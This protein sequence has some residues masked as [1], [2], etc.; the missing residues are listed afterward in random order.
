MR[1]SLG[2]LYFSPAK[3]LTLRPQSMHSFSLLLFSAQQSGFDTLPTHLLHQKSFDSQAQY[4][5]L[6][7]PRTLFIFYRISPL[8]SSTNSKFSSLRTLS[9]NFYFPLWAHST[10]SSSISSLLYVIASITIGFLRFFLAFSSVLLHD[11]WGFAY[12]TISFHQ[13]LPAILSP[14]TP[15]YFYHL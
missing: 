9:P 15:G 5:F 4:F 8:P 7:Q 2:L 1:L 13:F 12:T 6:F 14:L 10:I 11:G 3:S